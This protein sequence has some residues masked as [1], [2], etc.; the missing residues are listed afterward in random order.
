MYDAALVSPSPLQ[1][2]LWGQMQRR[3][4]VFG[5]VIVLIAIGAIWG[6]FAWKGHQ[7][8]APKRQ[9]MSFAQSF[10]SSLTSGDLSTV[11]DL[12]ILPPVYQSRTKQEQEDF[13]GKAL[14]DEISEEGLLVLQ[15]EGEFGPLLDIFPEKAT[16]WTSPLGINPEQC[17]AFRLESGPLTSE[18]VLRKTDEGYQVIR[19]NNIEESAR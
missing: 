15:R 19:C 16:A 2:W 7:A 4:L 1:R 13:L 18:L 17:V 14:R 5:L 6:W 9:A 3:H 11:R 12:T 10:E 8:Q